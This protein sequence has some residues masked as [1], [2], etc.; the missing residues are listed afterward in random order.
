MSTDRERF[1]AWARPHYD[2]GRD[3]PDGHYNS[4]ATN[5]AWHIWQ[6][7]LSES[8]DVGFVSD[9]KIEDSASCSL[10]G[11]P[12]QFKC[13]KCGLS[14]VPTVDV[15]AAALACAKEIFSIP[16]IWVWTDLLQDVTSTLARHMQGLSRKEG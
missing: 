12:M 6:A 8:P 13:P 15:D 14:P 3:R 16:G 1:E 7:A 10:C 5:L 2:L 4:P 9:L 11:T